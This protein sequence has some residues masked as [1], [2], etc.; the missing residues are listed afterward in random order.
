VSS[1]AFQGCKKAYHNG[2][3]YFMLHLKRNDQ[4][5][6]DVVQG[7]EKSANLKMVKQENL[8]F[9]PSINPSVSSS[10]SSP[11]RIGKNQVFPVTSSLTTTV[12]PPI[13]TQNL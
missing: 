7:K 11:L 3:F 9:L 13:C 4:D 1:Y 6:G 10:I 8:S 12:L 2:A 5:Q